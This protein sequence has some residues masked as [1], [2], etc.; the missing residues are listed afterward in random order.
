MSKNPNVEVIHQAMRELGPA[1]PLFSALDHAAAELAYL[2]VH[3]ERGR[4]IDTDER[5]NC[6]V[7][8]APATVISPGCKLSTVIESIRLRADLREPA[9]FK[10]SAS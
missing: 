9:R 3:L 1:H 8:I 2:H 7:Q 6:A 4:A 10:S 5:I